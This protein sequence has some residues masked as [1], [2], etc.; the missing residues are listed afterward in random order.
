MIYF[1]FLVLS[2]SYKA[3]QAFMIIGCLLLAALLGLSVLVAVGKSS[4]ST[5]KII[6][7]TSSAAGKQHN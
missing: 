7:A 6:V 4:D 1:L 3:V 2:D 5:S